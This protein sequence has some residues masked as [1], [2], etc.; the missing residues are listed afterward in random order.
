[1]HCGCR[2]QYPRCVP[3]KKLFAALVQSQA[4]FQAASG[5]DR[6]ILWEDVAAAHRAYDDHLHGWR[7]GDM[8]VRRSENET[9]RLE[10]RQGGQWIFQCGMTTGE[11][12]RAKLREQGFWR[13]AQ[14]DPGMPQ[15]H[16]TG[17]YHQRTTL[18]R[19]LR[20]TLEHIPPLTEP[21]WHEVQGKEFTQQWRIALSFEER[22]TELALLIAVLVGR[23]PQPLTPVE[24]LHIQ[25]RAV[26]WL[27]SH[28]I[29]HVEAP[30]L[31]TIALL[32]EKAIYSGPHPEC[33]SS[34]RR[35][36]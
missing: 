19:H 36:A 10:R 3:G 23:H 2:V 31:R 13:Y 24:R 15:D 34:R 17:Y 9:W 12:L 29:E 30:D 28:G 33:L 32:I 21:L 4:Q 25:R 35:Q 22:L 16:L 7:Q 18:T 26:H 14:I 27:L 20:D 1:M 8:R 5:K 6:D 11:A